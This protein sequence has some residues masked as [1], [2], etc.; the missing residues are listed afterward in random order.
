M[1]WQCFA[2]FALLHV[3]TSKENK[4]KNLLIRCT[5]VLLGVVLM[6]AVALAQSS[7]PPTCCSREL[8]ASVSTQVQPAEFQRVQL[9][10][11]ADASAAL[12]MTRRQFVDRLAE[13]L[14]PGKETYL[15]V[16][17]TRL[18]AP[19][20]LPVGSSNAAPDAGTDSG[21]MAI[22]EMRYY[23]VSKAQLRTEDLDS[24]THLYLTDG[25]TYLRVSFVRGD[26]LGF[27][28]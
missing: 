18:L 13:A 25:Q 15:V 6:S 20:E 4:M 10:V 21:L 2:C 9:I 12:G 16:P 5:S 14:L 8:L 24:L 22:Q 26:I 7:G 23:K 11:S 1:P 27:D 3:S 28:E 17:I 19:A